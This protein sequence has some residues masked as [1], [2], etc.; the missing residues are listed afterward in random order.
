M[1]GFDE[2]MEDFS[3][4]KAVMSSSYRARDAADEAHRAIDRAT[5]IAEKGQEVPLVITQAHRVGFLEGTIQKTEQFANQT[6]RENQELREQLEEMTKDRDENKLA[7][8][9]QHELRREVASELYA[10]QEKVK[11]AAKR[12]RR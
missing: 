7:Y 6:A 5:K 3:P 9:Q 4:E 11:A 1:R 8:N 2:S 12:R 10:L